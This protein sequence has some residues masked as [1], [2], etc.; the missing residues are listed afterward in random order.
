M[1]DGG[2]TTRDRAVVRHCEARLGAEAIQSPRGG[3]WI[4][5]GAEAALAMTAFPIIKG[6]AGD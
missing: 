5:R 3:L 4:A 1:E 6:E 2:W